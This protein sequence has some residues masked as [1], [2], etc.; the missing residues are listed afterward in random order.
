V[1]SGRLLSGSPVTSSL[2]S[3]LGAE[4]VVLYTLPLGRWTHRAAC[5]SRGLVWRYA[6]GVGSG[7]PAIRPMMT[8]SGTLRCTIMFNGRPWYQYLLPGEG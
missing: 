1:S 8:L 5:Q 3:T 2:P 6:M 4:Y 7:V